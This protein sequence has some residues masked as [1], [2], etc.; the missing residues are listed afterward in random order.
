MFSIKIDSN[1]IKEVKLVDIKLIK[2]HEEVIFE[3]KSAF[4]NYLNSLDYEIIISSIIVCHKTHTIIDGHH[5]YSA[6][7]E[8]GY[9]KI[10][11]TYIK[12]SDKYIKTHIDDR[13]SKETILNSSL[14]RKLLSPKS[15]RHLV[16]D[17]NT[18]K[19]KPIILIS[20][21]FN[22]KIKK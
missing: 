1:I 8:L 12:Y 17:F 2:A 10:P 14:S 13:I 4:M 22:I 18:N 15:S 16:F 19:W 7:K 20:S 6:L 21:L 5:R 9:T 3:R 11:V